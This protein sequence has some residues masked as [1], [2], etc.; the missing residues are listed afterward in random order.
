[1]E[2]QVGQGMRGTW[3]RRGDAGEVSGREVVPDAIHEL[4]RAS[5]PGLARVSRSLEASSSSWTWRRRW[6]P[7]RR[8]LGGVA[9]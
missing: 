3:A 8:V 6:H 4:G 7:G 5:A 9:A 2:G 1:M